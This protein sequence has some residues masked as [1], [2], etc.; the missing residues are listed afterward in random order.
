M[1]ELERKKITYCVVV[2][3]GCTFG[4]LPSEQDLKID[5]NVGRFIIGVKRI[6]EV[7]GE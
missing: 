2:T 4:R 5:K 7:S 6:R 3:E 1:G